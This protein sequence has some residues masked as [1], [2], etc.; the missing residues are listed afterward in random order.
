MKHRSIAVGMAALLF[1]LIGACSEAATPATQAET[2]YLA[3]VNALETEVQDVFA[4]IGETLNT[5][6]AL[7]SVLYDALEKANLT[8]ALESSLERVEQ[9]APPDRFRADHERFI[10]LRQNAVQL[11]RQHDKAVEDDDI[12]EVFLIRAQFVV[13]RSNFFINISPKFCAGIIPE[14]IGVQAFDPRCGSDSPLPGGAYGVNLRAIMEQYQADFSSRV[15]SFPLMM[16]PDEFF[17]ALIRLNPEIEVA[18]EQALLAAQE[19]EP[20]AEFLTDHGRLLQYFE[21]N[22]QLS[23][24]ITSAARNREGDKLR[25]E[26]FPESGAVLER[27]KN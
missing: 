15:A 4:E 14:S 16:S 21:E 11:S 12:V 10:E 1:L 18:I 6:Y 8:A 5:T 13:A 26:Y 19:L 22:L 17:T 7:K 24:A 2:D 3:S 27:A 25:M 23:R 20:P 9:L